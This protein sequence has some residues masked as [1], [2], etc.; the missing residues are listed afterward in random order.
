MEGLEDLV[1]RLNSMQASCDGIAE[2]AIKSAAELLKQ[3]IESSVA[4]SNINHKHIRD[5]I[6]ISKFMGEGTRKYVVIGPAK[7]NWRAKFLEFGTKHMNAK[8]FMQPSFER[9][10]RSMFEKI[11]SIIRGRLG[12]GD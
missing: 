12:I 10:K 3:E 5:D 1:A 8:P 2:D 11:V 9:K 4:V 7:T 6:R